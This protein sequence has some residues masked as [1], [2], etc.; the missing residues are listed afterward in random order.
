MEHS[1]N[2]SVFTDTIFSIFFYN[3]LVTL[4]FAESIK[5]STD[6]EGR[7]VDIN[8]VVKVLLLIFVTIVGVGVGTFAF[9]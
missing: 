3:K 5:V 7:M 6:V 8:R 4:V 2:V 9:C 1:F